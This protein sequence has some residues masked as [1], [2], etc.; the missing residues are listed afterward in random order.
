MESYCAAVYHLALKPLRD[1]FPAFSNHWVYCLYFIVLLYNNGKRFK[2]VLEIWH[3][4]SRYK[5]LSTEAPA[6]GGVL[7]KKVFL[8]ISQNSQENTCA[9]VSFL[10]KLQIQPAALL[11]KRLWNRFSFCELY[12]IFQNT[13]FSNNTSRAIAFAL[14]FFNK[15]VHQ[16]S[17]NPFIPNATFLHP[18]KT[19]ENLTVFWCFKGIQKGCIGNKCVKIL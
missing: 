3:E 17:I 5:C 10:I 6:T 16:D 9:R 19:L 8:K 12:E 18:L 4:A 13:F 14:N 1:F 2:R 7:W 15:T 11:T